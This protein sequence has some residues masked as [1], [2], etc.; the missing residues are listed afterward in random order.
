VNSNDESE[1]SYEE[2]I[3]GDLKNDSEA[4]SEEENI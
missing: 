4:I 2:N 3:F 1:E